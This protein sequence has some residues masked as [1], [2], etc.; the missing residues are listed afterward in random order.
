MKFLGIE[1][2]IIGDNTS[3]K[4]ILNILHEMETHFKIFVNPKYLDKFFFVVNIY[5]QNLYCDMT[6]I[7]NTEDEMT[8]SS[9]FTIYNLNESQN[10]AF[11]YEQLKTDYLDILNESDS[12]YSC[13]QSIENFDNEHFPDKKD[14]DNSHFNNAI[15]TFQSNNSEHM[16]ESFEHFNFEENIEEFT[17]E[18]DSDDSNESE[19]EEGPT[20]EEGAKPSPQKQTI[21]I[22]K[23]DN[24]S[25]AEKNSNDNEEENFKK[26]ISKVINCSV[27]TKKYVKISLFKRDAHYDETNKTV[28]YDRE[29]LLFINSFFISNVEKIKN[30]IYNVKHTSA[31][32]KQFIEE[33]L[34]DSLAQL[35]RIFK[36]CYELNNIY[37]S[38]TQYTFDLINILMTNQSGVY[39]NPLDIR[40]S[41]FINR[42][43][44]SNCSNDEIIDKFQFMFF[45]KVN[46]RDVYKHNYNKKSVID[47]ISFSIDSC[48]VCDLCG[49]VGSTKTRAYFYS[50]PNA[51]DI[52]RVCYEDKKKQFYNRIKYIKSI[53]LREGK[54]ALFLKQKEAISLKLST[55]KIPKLSKSKKTAI[56]DRA[57]KLITKTY[58]P[59]TCKICF[60]EIILQESSS[61]NIHK[62]LEHEINMGNT[63]VTVSSC[64]HIFHTQCVSDLLNSETCP[65]CRQESN[66]TRIFL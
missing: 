22:L 51:G 55:M 24:S 50:E 26:S 18:D 33:N 42:E 7:E 47:R 3:I 27:K 62:K 30:D 52:C 15:F 36:D 49:E 12:V 46:Y 4:H 43:I 65:Y 45:K 2:K 41:I 14:S 10:S 32:D 56:S 20:P 29:C 61:P 19:N 39:L 38:K 21:D 63:N 40:F 34:A 1:T 9:Y 66:F 25:D 5:G 11:L 6:N 64:G 57:F 23:L 35:T 44:G 16:D 59:P 31:N 60:G 48:I 28:I 17:E 37:L 8:C 13:I 58:N 54:R 53:I